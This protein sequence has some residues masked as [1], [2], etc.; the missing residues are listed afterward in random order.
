[1]SRA[2]RNGAARLR[3]R[4]LV[5]LAVVVP[6]A[7]IMVAALAAWLVLRASLPRLDGRAARSGVHAEVRVSRDA[8]GVPT[9]TA[10]NRSDLAFALGYVH[11]QDRFFQMDLLRRAAA[12]EL[13]AL[14]GPA[15]LPADRELR[16]H[17]FRDVAERAVAN[18]DAR[19]RTL[20]DAYADGANAGL[21]ALR[22]RPFE[23]WLLRVD[24][25]PWSAADTVL[26]VHAMFLQLQDST[27]HLQLQR[28]LLR[29]T[30]PEALAR[31][32]EAG[33]PEWDAAIDG[34]LAEP[35]RIPTP[36]EFDLRSL[37]ALPVTPPVTLTAS[38]D[39]VG[40]NNWAVAG[41][42]TGGGAALVANDMHLDLRVPNIWYRARLIDASAQGFDEVGLTLPGAPTLVVGSNGHIAWGFTNSYGEFSKV[43]RLVPVP[44]DPDA[45]ATAAGTKKLDYVD[46]TI[47]V[48]GAPPEH[49][50]VAVTPWGPVMG[51]D[52]QNRPY[53]LDWVAHD[54]AAVN[55]NLLALE[56]IHSAAEA[57]RAAGGFGIP[58]QNFLVGD[59]EGHIGWSIARPAAASQRCTARA[60]TTLHRSR[61]RLR[62]LALPRGT[63]ASA[64]PDRRPALV[65]QRPCH[66][67]RGR[68]PHRR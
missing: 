49:L 13:A 3:A 56:H 30:L 9:L 5:V 65:G 18:L 48:K 53:V 4:R 36:G 47:E 17:R 29:A 61:G 45:Y 28:G 8:A 32:I 51:T 14:L 26:C 58:G 15:L 24:P 62:G 44:G 23:Y 12:G 33:A 37:G 39:P 60:A 59:A 34:S 6:A 43:I 22:A 63:T 64:R 27:G 1:M 2:P 35:P 10:Q 7:T 67:R 40:S 50:R 68:E 38:P 66:R 21:S 55:M 16:R 11:A 41:S 31:F 46:E 42:R 25:K 57:L 20:L 54:P 52:W 19:S